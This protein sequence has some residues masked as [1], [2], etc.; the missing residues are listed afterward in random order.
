MI[1]IAHYAV[2]SRD[3]TV[4]SENNY[5]CQFSIVNSRSSHL[6]QTDFHLHPPLPP[7]TFASHQLTKEDRPKEVVDHVI[8]TTTTDAA[9][10]F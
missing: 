10:L 8:M 2:K 3:C 1:Y 6:F 7:L 9:I 5:E 4:R